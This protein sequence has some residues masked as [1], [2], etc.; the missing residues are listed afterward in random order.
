MIANWLKERREADIKRQANEI[1]KAFVEDLSTREAKV[2]TGQDTS[3]NR[4]NEPN[5]SENRKD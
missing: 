5:D 4:N 3:E 2:P 1:A